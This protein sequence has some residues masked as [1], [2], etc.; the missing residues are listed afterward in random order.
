M[1]FS[2]NE[3]PADATPPAKRRPRREV[4][5]LVLFVLLLGLGF[6]ALALRPVNDHVVVPFTAG[7]ARVSAVALRLLGQ[8]IRIEGTEIYGPR[9]AVAIENGCNGVET[10]TIFFAAILAF[11]AAWSSRLLGIAIGFV[12]IQLLNLVRVIALF[13]TGS[14]LPDFFDTSHTVVWQSVVVATSLLLWLFWA[15]RF[16]GRPGGAERTA[17]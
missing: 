6:S 11:P 3:S 7:V 12:G 1:P 9:F 14:Y 8:E 5:F 17:T 16:A 13:L 4:R 2:K 15:Q 10:M